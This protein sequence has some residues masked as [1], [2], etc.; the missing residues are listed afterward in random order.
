MYSYWICIY[1]KQTYT[2]NMTSKLFCTQKHS[3]VATN[4]PVAQENRR[5]R[6]P[7]VITITLEEIFVYNI[8]RIRWRRH[9]I[10]LDEKIEKSW[11]LLECRPIQMAPQ[12][13]ISSAMSGQALSHTHIPVCMHT[14]EQKVYINLEYIYIYI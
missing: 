3:R 10:Q 1:G 13:I 14:L 5:M 7:N 8:K 4:N 6:V 2:V 12:K 11:R 9:Y